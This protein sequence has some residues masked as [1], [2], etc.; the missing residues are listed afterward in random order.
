MLYTANISRER[1]REEQHFLML[2]K[3]THYGKPNSFPNHILHCVC[4]W[5][6]RKKILKTIHCKYLQ[7]EGQ[8]SNL[9]LRPEWTQYGKPSSLS[10]HICQWVCAWKWARSSEELV[11]RLIHI[12]V[13]V[14]KIFIIN[15]AWLVTSYFK[16][17]DL[18]V[19]PKFLFWKNR[20]HKF[21]TC[22]TSLVN[23]QIQDVLTIFSFENKVDYI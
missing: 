15:L 4:A 16:E 10:N 12:W 6:M 22:V 18:H 14:W 7:G 20:S 1:V 23:E 2:D 9:L 8:S 11:E 19:F 21:G 13:G 5:K 3:A 17:N